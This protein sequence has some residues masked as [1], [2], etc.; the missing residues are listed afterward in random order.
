MTTKKN[1]VQ[2]LSQELGPMTFGRFLR[3]ART[4]T[5]LTQAE[6]AR[7]LDISRSTL[8][9][10]EKGRQAVSAELAA[11]IART[12]GVSEVMAVEL[13][14]TEQLRRA[15]LDMRVSVQPAPASSKRIRRPTP[16]AARQRR[17]PQ[18]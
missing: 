14:L 10:I 6:L 8:C 15:Q 1:L 9:D 16:L 2:L 11:R 17:S 5:D 12:C 3:S 4:T 18:R 7:R 13:V